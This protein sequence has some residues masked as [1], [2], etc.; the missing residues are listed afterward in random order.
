MRPRHPGVGEPARVRELVR[1][2]PAAVS[3]QRVADP[4]SAAA[5]AGGALALLL[6]ADAAIAKI[7]TALLQLSSQKCCAN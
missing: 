3:A 5:V 2:L 6:A 1:A 4:G 7:C